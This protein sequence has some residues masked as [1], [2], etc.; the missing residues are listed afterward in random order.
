MLMNQVGLKSK[1]LFQKEIF[2]SDNKSMQ[3]INNEQHNRCG[4]TLE[5]E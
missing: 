5:I 4:M 1:K 3:K 2:N